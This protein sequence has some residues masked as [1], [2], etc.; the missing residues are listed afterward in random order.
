MFL[1]SLKVLHFFNFPSSFAVKSKR[2]T[3]WKTFKF[4]QSK[5][6]VEHTSKHIVRPIK[7]IFQECKVWDNLWQMCLTRVTQDIKSH[8]GHT[9]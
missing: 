9:P 5:S 6:L 1:L 8:T 4:K 7:L 3:V 2:M